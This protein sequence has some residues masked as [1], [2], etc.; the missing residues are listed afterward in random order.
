MKKIR[1]FLAP[2][3]QYSR[4]VHQYWFPVTKGSSKI[5]AIL[6]LFLICFISSLLYFLVFGSISLANIAMPELLT[7]YTPGLVDWVQKIS[8]GNLRYYFYGS[9]VVFPLLYILFRKNIKGRNYA[10]FLMFVLLTL[11]MMVSGINVIL[12]YVGRFW[13][14][15]LQQ[16]DANSFWDNIKFHLL[17]Y[18]VAMPIVVFYPW[19][20]GKL[21][22]HWRKYLTDFFTKNYFKNRAYFEIHSS[23]AIDNPDQRIAEDIRSFT[24]TSL[25]FLL[26]ILGSLIDL[27]AFTFVLLSI[28]KLLTQVLLIYAV[29]GTILTVLIGRPLFKINFQQLRLEANYRYALVH[30]RDNAESIA[31]YKGE[32]S[33]KNILKE[34]FT[35]IVRN[36]NR[37]I[38]WQRNLRV[39]TKYYN[40][41][42]VLLP[43][44]ILAPLYFSKQIEFG[45]MYQAAFA[46]SMILDALSFIVV[47]FND[48]S[49]YAAATNRLGSF[50]TVLDHAT[51]VR[52]TEGLADRNRVELEAADDYAIDNLDLFTPDFKKNLIKAL[53]TD[54][55][56]GKR[57]LIAGP[58]GSG[59]SS[60]VRTLA[61]LWRSGSGTI[62]YPQNK[63]VFFIPQKPYITLGSLKEQILYPYTE[64][65]ADE[66]SVI[67]LLNTVNL[68][69]L[70]EQIKSNPEVLTS[71]NINWNET[72]SLGEQQR[73]AFSR[74]L[75]AKPDYAILDE[76]TSAL[77]V[78]NERSIYTK[79]SASSV[80]YISVGHRPQLAHYHDAVLLLDG[81]GGWQI[82]SPDDYIKS[83]MV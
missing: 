37:L 2:L 26:I 22:I 51:G 57:L 66:N 14:T 16:M 12:S 21:G 62:K 28:S 71:N 64:R 29:G 38:G 78:D 4:L 49:S 56:A 46:F 39:F 67:E 61:G 80:T 55:V 42:V 50:E 30:T 70:S 53:S 40:Y 17:V 76:A 6:V 69:E 83:L 44:M 15:A 5:F 18:V 23:K 27:V 25:S 74:L 60:L 24:S 9:I 58:S 81:K 68:P 1:E 52:S 8:S 33:E 7:K 13:Q 45:K 73:L 43:Y 54:E 48:I 3:A 20:Q 63:K 36:F 77:D 72:L 47:Y 41:M 75:F 79:L 11:A 35:E 32:Q 10:W 59:K 31:F 34:R 19:V 82:L 65:D